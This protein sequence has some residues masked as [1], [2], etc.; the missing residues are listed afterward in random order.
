MCQLLVS[1]FPAGTTI[2]A[3]GRGVRVVAN[4]TMET[5]VTTSLAV[6]HKHIVLKG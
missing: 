2:V 3:V 1:P 6:C 5:I 4:V